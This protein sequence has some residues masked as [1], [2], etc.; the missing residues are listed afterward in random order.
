MNALF[1]NIKNKV[2][3]F[4]SAEKRTQNFEEIIVNHSQD[5]EIE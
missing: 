5:N 3:T 2:S 1:G 4:F